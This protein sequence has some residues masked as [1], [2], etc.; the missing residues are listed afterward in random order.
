MSEE[1]RNIVRTPVRWADGQ[2]PART[3]RPQR[4]KTENTSLAEKRMLSVREAA[5]YLGLAEKTLRNRIGPSAANPF[6][7]RPKR[8]AGCHK[9]LFDKREL[10][11]Y[12]DELR[13]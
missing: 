12:L 10:D 2:E 5:N 6:P 7:V 11:R 13:C 3:K 4:A 9:P 1:A 8:I